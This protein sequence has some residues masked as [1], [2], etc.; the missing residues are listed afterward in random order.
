MVDTSFTASRELSFSFTCP[1]NWGSSS[2]VD[3][4]KDMRP[5]D[6][7]LAQLHTTREEGVMFGK[8]LHRIEN[9]GAQTGLMGAALQGRNEVDVGFR[10]AAGFRPGH[11]PGRTFAL[12][13]PIG[14]VRVDLASERQA[15]GLRQGGPVRTGSRPARPGSNRRALPPR[16]DVRSPAGRVT[17]GSR[18]GLGAQQT[19]EFA[20]GDFGRF[21]E[22]RIGPDMHR[23][24]RFFPGALADDR[25][26]LADPVRHPQTRLR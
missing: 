13:K 10:K 22:G 23:G 19:R 1:W 9:A 18:Y 4:T 16:R 11:R 3:S 6:I 15:P 20:L 2:R 8:R 7:F 17:P 24:A 25:E 12:G 21:E 5:V 14:P 26:L